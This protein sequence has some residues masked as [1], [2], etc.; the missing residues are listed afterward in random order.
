MI[1]KKLPLVARAD[2]S[3]C[4]LMTCNKYLFARA[5]IAVTLPKDLDQSAELGFKLWWKAARSAVVSTF[6]HFTWV[7]LYCIV[8]VR[9]NICPTTTGL[10][11]DEWI[12]GWFLTS[13]KYWWSL[14]KESRA[15]L[16][17]N[18]YWL[19][20]TICND[21][22]MTVSAQNPACSLLYKPVKVKTQPETAWF[23]QRQH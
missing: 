8:S 12:E 22:T 15:W 2:S 13:I 10:M 16:M 3:I 5:V 1:E 18:C 14:L 11:G 6:N 9:V 20:C 4:L 17:I 23:N 21:G 19:Q 7:L